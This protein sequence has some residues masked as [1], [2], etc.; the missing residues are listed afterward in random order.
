MK[1]NLS[2]LVKKLC[3]TVVL[4]AAS[5]SA[6]AGLNLEQQRQVYEKAQDLI[7][8]NDVEGYLKFE[9]RER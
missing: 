7:D 3:C 4:C 1:Y 9:K 6:A 8:Q 5:V 2:D